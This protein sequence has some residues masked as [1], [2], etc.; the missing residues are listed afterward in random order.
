MLGWSKEV[1]PQQ[2]LS[3][4]QTPFSTHTKCSRKFLNPLSSFRLF[5]FMQLSLNFGYF[6]SLNIHSLKLLLLNFQLLQKFLERQL[7]LSLLLLERFGILTKIPTISFEVVKLLIVWDTWHVKELI[8]KLRE[9]KP[10][11]KLIAIDVSIANEKQPMKRI[12]QLL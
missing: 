10:N 6:N 9:I 8:R 3:L 4:I 11:L 12:L 2:F 5:T 1:K 7:Y